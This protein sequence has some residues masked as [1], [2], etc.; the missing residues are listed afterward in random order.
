M[1]I[2]RQFTYLLCRDLG[3]SEALPCLVKVLGP[4]GL[5]PNPKL[6]TIVTDV[7]PAVRTMKEGRVEFRCR[8][9]L[10]LIG[11]PPS[12]PSLSQAALRPVPHVYS[13][14]LVAPSIGTKA[15]G[16]RWHGAHRTVVLSP[17]ARN[18]QGVGFLRG[19]IVYD[20]SSCPCAADQMRCIVTITF[21]VCS[22][23]VAML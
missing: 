6:G 11:M 22:G 4:R 1:P 23:C 13:A 10:A 20:E 3:W 9:R 2:S 18:N 17:V 14:N 16:F 19:C 12:V 15:N 5:M 21:S 7:G 8:P